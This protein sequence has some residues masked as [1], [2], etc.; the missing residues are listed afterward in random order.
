[1]LSFAKILALINLNKR[2][3]NQ[4]KQVLVFFIRLLSL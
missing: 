2:F 1:M 3:I 4:E